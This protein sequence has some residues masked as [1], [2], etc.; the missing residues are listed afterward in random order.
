MSYLAGVDGG[1]SKTHCLIGDDLGNVISEGFSGGS[2]YQVIGVEEARDVI[3]AAIEGA[4]NKANIKVEELAYTVLG[5]AGADFEED[6]VVLGEICGEILPKDRY[7]ILNDSWIGLRAGIDANWGI[8]TVCGTAGACSGRSRDGKEVRLRNMTYEAGMRGGGND[9]TRMALH[10]AFRSDEGTG[11]KTLLEKELPGVFGMDTID[12]I[13]LNAIMIE[14]DTEAIQKIPVLVGELACKGDAV[15]QDIL[16]R[17]GHEL[18]EIA[19]G[20]VKRLDMQDEAFDVALIGGV[21]KSECPLL[22]DEYTTT[23]HRSAPKAKISVVGKAPVYG[24]Y[25]L[26]LEE[27]KKIK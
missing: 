26:A 7:K 8:A 25:Y 23:L 6:Y 12:E 19:G 22:K 1:N 10:Y 14:S 18:G 4:A 13:I 20:V 15:C 5:L 21:F 24:A 2:N 11:Q 16:L 17:V 3:K 27:Y 9:I